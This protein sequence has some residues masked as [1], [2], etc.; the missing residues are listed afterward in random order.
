M[1]DRY[2]VVYEPD[3]GIAELGNVCIVE[4]EGEREAAMDG[5]VAMRCGN[6]ATGIRAFKLD[7]LPVGWSYYR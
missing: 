7:D 5:F 4:A 1:S 3:G 6:H 2:L